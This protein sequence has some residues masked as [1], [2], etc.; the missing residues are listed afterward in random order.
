MCSGLR[1]HKRDRGEG[2]K[3]H[4]PPCVAV[5]SQR[6]RR[7]SPAAGAAEAAG[8]AGMGIV[9]RLPDALVGFMPSRACCAAASWFAF[10]WSMMFC[11]ER[12]PAAQVYAHSHF[13]QSRCAIHAIS[14][15]SSQ[16]TYSRSAPRS[17]PTLRGAPRPS[18]AKA[19]VHG[20]GGQFGAH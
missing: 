18:C 14:S 15:H 3:A 5:W 1:G 6:F 10:V 19:G 13:M 2:E 16:P 4:S 20:R 11:R 9:G 12:S 8:A 7:L 17:C